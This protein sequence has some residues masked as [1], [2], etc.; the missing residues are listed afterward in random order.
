MAD[1]AERGGGADPVGEA[2]D[3]YAEAFRTRPGFRAMW[4]G[5]LRTEH[6]RDLT[7]PGLEDIARSLARAL[8][9]RPQTAAVARMAVLVADALL[10]AAFR[11]DP[12]GDEALLAEAKVLLRGYVNDRLRIAG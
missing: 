2:L 1:V 8:P 6:L 11:E 3:A 5:G 12:A 9:A 7:R 4:F 10:R